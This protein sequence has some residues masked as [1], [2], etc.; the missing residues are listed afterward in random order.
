[1][2]EEIN[3]KEIFKIF[4]HRYPFLLVEKAFIM[5]DGSVVG[6]KNVSLNEFWSIGHF[7]HFPIMPGVLIVETLSQVGGL[8]FI[9]DFFRTEPTDKKY[10]GYIAGYDKVRFYS[11][12]TPG[13]ILKFES[14]RVIKY[15]N[16]GKISGSAYAKKAFEPENDW[17][18]VLKAEITYKFEEMDKN[19]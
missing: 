19:I 16:I 10:I 4:P 7:P 6:Y 14:K 13:D 15:G 8:C 11:M 2:A 12:V 17:R 5:E 9:N 3:L 18:L 1:M